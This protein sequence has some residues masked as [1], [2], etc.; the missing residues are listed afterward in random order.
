MNMTSVVSH[1]VTLAIVGALST[2]A[3]VTGHITGEAWAGLMAGAAGFSFGAGATA[4][5]ATALQRAGTSS[6]GAAP[7]PL[8]PTPAPAQPAD[9]PK[10]A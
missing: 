7:L 2:V 4:T 3:L 9:L 5:V 8:P 10:A 6:G 1:L